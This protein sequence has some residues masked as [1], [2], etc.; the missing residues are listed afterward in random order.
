MF[1]P[2]YVEFM[3]ES[4]RCLYLGLYFRVYLITHSVL[5]V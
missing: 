4:L 2:E 5:S 3:R 1:D